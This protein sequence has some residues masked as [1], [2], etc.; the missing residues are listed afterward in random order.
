MFLYLVRHG[1]TMPKEHNPEQPLSKQGRAM[2]R[3]VA[4]VVFRTARW[5][6]E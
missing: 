2:V 3:R 6:W 4:E 1:A 5:T